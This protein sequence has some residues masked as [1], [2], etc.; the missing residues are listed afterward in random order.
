MMDPDTGKSNLKDGL[1]NA[2]IHSLFR[3][4]LERRLSGLIDIGANNLYRQIPD[5][6][7]SFVACI[8][9]GAPKENGEDQPFIFLSRIML[10][11]FSFF[12]P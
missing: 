5:R 4:G 11:M 8:S 9:D 7:L 12:P 1:K 10:Q 6:L 2:S 3:L